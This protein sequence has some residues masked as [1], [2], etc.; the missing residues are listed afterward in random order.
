MIDIG[1]NIYAIRDYNTHIDIDDNAIIE[2]LNINN[3]YLEGPHHG[4]NL[5][6]Y[7]GELPDVILKGVTFVNSK[8]SPK[9]IPS[10]FDEKEFRPFAKT[11]FKN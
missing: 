4:F 7:R 9:L 5:F 1:Y 3:V 6:C 8:L 10:K 11:N 2:L